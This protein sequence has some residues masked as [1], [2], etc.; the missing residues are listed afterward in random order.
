MA[1]RT[2]TI[3]LEAYEILSRH[4][5]PGAPFSDVIKQ[6]LGKGLTARDLGVVIERARV[7]EDALSAIDAVIRARRRSPARLVKR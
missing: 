1:V 7:G 4:K 5:G 2:I 3:D 6:R